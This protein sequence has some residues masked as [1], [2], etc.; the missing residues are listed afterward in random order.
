M[1]ADLVYVKSGVPGVTWPPMVKSANVRLLALVQ[2]LDRSQW[3]AWSALQAAQQTQLAV[4][5]KHF[6]LQ[7]PWVRDQLRQ[8]GLSAESASQSWDAFAHYPVT[9]RA[10]ILQAGPGLLARVVPPSHLPVTTRT[11]SGSTGVPVTAHRSAVNQLFWQATTLREHLWHQ[12]D[13]KGRLAVIRQS[14][15][16]TFDHVSW[17]A[18]VANLFDTGT[19][20]GMPINTAPEDLLQWLASVQP[21]YL[22]VYPGLWQTLLDLMGTPSGA[23]ALA[24]L[25]SMAQVRTVGQSVSEGLRQQ[26]QATLGIRIAD[27]Y[28]SEE[29]GVIAIECPHSGLY[30]VMAE[31]LVVE[32]LA[33]DGSACQNGDIGRV[34]VTELLNFASP[35][36]RYDL[37]DYAQV[38]PPCACGRGLPTLAKIVG[39]QRNMLRLPDGSRR[40]RMAGYPAFAPVANITQYQLVQTS[41][42]QI[43]VYLAVDGPALTTSQEAQL[44]AIL[45]DTM[46]CRFEYRFVYP[47]GGLTMPASGKFEEFVCEC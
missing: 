1:S 39:R 20:H 37:G 34:V 7:S 47:E 25:A 36:I 24:A 46:P 40:W 14:V 27:T 45:H 3:L 44:A 11:T 12:R 5:L 6:E 32:V 21:T 30:H 18:P 17:G 23:P 43:E 31:G 13:P 42:T 10:D 41:P 4:L 33:P 8:H 15:A 22:L 19:S 16:K 28:S 2:W 29:A 26:T 38:G 9:T 35:V